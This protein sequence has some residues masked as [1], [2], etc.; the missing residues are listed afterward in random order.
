[1]STT[2]RWAIDPAHSS[3]EFRVPNFWGLVKVKGDDRGQEPRVKSVPRELV[4]VTPLDRE[5]SP[6]GAATWSYSARAR[7]A[8]SPN[9]GG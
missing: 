9:R 3:A 5:P 4:L 8:R 2:T 7:G 1:M 6:A